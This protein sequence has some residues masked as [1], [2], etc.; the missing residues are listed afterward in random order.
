MG[1]ADNCTIWRVVTSKGVCGRCGAI[2]ALYEDAVM[3]SKSIPPDDY[4]CGSLL[5]ATCASKEVDRR[6]KLSHK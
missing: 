4:R 5:C 1:Q 3:P 6:I 2:G